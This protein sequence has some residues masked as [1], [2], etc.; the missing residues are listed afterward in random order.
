[1]L[2]DRQ[3]GAGAGRREIY[4]V[5]SHDCGHDDGAWGGS[6]ELDDEML[7]EMLFAEGSEP[8]A[9]R[10][11]AAAAGR[12]RYVVGYLCG[13][14]FLGG[15][16]SKWFRELPGGQVAGQPRW[17]L[18]TGERNIQFFWSLEAT[19]SRVHRDDTPSILVVLAGRK[20]VHLWLRRAARAEDSTAAERDQSTDTANPDQVVHLE[21]GDALFIPKKVWHRVQSD[22]ATFALS[23]RV[24]AQRRASLIG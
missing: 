5:R 16:L 4:D 23:F 9:T 2:Y 20:E 24:T 17:P 15:A 19:D 22:A 14:R 11:R 6:V 8:G 21:P 12:R 18:P 3:D 10:D 1:M 13:K 7:R